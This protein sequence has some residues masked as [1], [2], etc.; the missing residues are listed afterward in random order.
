MNAATAVQ[1]SFHYEGGVVEYVRYI[2]KNKEVLHPDPIYFSAVKNDNPLETAS[3]EVALQYNDGYSENVFT[4]A[5]NINTIEG[6]ATLRVSV[7]Q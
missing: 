2:N 5:N 3:V 4:Y 1:D 7:R 6:G